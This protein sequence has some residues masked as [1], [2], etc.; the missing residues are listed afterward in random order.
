MLG[1]A[2][3]AG[4]YYTA[5][6]APLRKELIAGFGTRTRNTDERRALIAD[7][8]AQVAAGSVDVGEALSLVPALL[9]D[10]DLDVVKDGLGLL[11]LIKRDALPDPLLASYQRM[12]R[13]LLG[14]RALEIGWRS[15][16]GEPIEL[17]D[18]RPEVIRRAA[19][20][21]GDERL[22]AEARRLTVAWLAD[23][24]STDPDMNDTMLELAA[25]Y[26]DAAL[27]DALLA[28]AL[29]TE[30][31][32]H[33]RVLLTSLGGFQNARLLARALELLLDPKIDLRD[34][35]GLL[36]RALPRRETREQVWAFYKQHFA[37]LAVRLRDDEKSGLILRGV[38][39]FC[40]AA[41]RD[42][43][44]ALLAE[45]ASHI[46]GGPLVLAMALESVDQCIAT[47]ERNAAGIAAFL[48][49]Y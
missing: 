47:R 42:E 10:T 48:Q 33:D 5:Y 38:Y 36:W 27:F 12:G 15:T 44:R 18:L 41:H 32:E 8:A 46:D 35:L 14:A 20:A 49:E 19:E 2:G 34:S 45:P 39:D 23:R 28:E 9:A 11:D 37:E 3:G 24:K 40:D 26:G 1:N 43:A 17:H 16:P 30:D 29:H 7:L 22:Y 31:R 6:S 25:R 13:K 21:G 4:Y